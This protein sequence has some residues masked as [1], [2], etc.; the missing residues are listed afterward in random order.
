ME[1][2]KAKLQELGLMPAEAA[3][4]PA[5]ASSD[6]P[7]PGELPEAAAQSDGP[8]AG[9]GRD[10]SSAKVR[11]LPS[12]RWRPCSFAKHANSGRT[13]AW[14][15]GPRI[16]GPLRRHGPGPRRRPGPQCS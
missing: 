16:A 10:R 12:P 13:W 15:R 3:A 6:V 5:A 14:D 4:Q 8:S 2:A 1:Q 7:E 9:S 11:S